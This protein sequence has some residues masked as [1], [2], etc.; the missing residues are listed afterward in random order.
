MTNRDPVNP[1]RGHEP[2]ARHVTV[3]ILMPAGRSDY[4][5]PETMPFIHGLS[6]ASMQG[7]F[8]SP[9][10]PA[11]R[12]VLFSGRYPDTSGMFG[13]YAFDPELSPFAWVR[14]LGP[15][16]NLVRPHTLMLPARRAIAKVTKWRTKASTNDP[17]WI[18]PR[19]LPFF[20]PCEDARPLHEEGALG[21]TS[22]FDLCRKHG[23]SY[24]YLAHPVGDDDGDAEIHRTLVRELRDGAPCDLYVVQ[25]GAT[26]HLG[27]LHGPFSDTMQK[28][29]LR[30]L[31]GKLASVHAALSA[32]H[33]SWDLF[34]CGDR[35]MAPVNRRVDILRTLRGL[36]VKPAK[37]YVL[38]VHSTLAVLWYLTEK[39]RL[40]I[41]A[42]LPGIPGT[43]IV[44]D[45]ERR[46]HRIP[47]GRPWGE[48]LL[49][50]EPGVLFSP[51][52]LYVT[53]AA[54]AGMHGYL[55]KREET[56]GMALLAS[57]NGH[58]GPRKLGLRP[59]VDV[60]PTLCDLLKV[61]VPSG[62]EGTSLFSGFGDTPHTIQPPA[63]VPET[64]P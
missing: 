47:P 49:A 63:S 30:E 22:I 34:V 50:A 64:S 29:F 11:R 37:D 55:D 15:L 48:R 62:Q 12:N 42:A 51:D 5:R 2:N 1:N 39:G 4:V 32:N 31:D 14:A 40:A 57:S 17:A 41:E 38:F 3:F 27:R 19:F 10:G 21:A 13:A 26:D 43:H 54:I 60:F 33:E 25:L 61:P 6:A 46:R 7:S 28:R 35:G 52:Y 16:G 59:L 44:D 36:D 23:L 58:T 20:R 45:E 53:D 18:P 9:A 56:H 24:R 8:E